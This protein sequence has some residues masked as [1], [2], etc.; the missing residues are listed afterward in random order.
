M[1]T[2]AIVDRIEPLREWLDGSPVLLM[3]NGKVYRKRLR[4]ENISM[5]ELDKVAR[6]YG[7]PSIDGFES[8]TLEGDGSITGVL[9]KTPTN[10]AQGGR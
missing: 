4:K 8:M 3:R 5:E 2:M 10:I 9:R 6:E 7:L 1:G